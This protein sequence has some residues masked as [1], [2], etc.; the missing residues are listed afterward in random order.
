M[1]ELTNIRVFNFEGAIRGM[2]QPFKNTQKS[3][4][5]FG[6][7]SDEY[8][9]DIVSDWITDTFFIDSSDEFECV[10]SYYDQGILNLNNDED[11]IQYALLGP[12]DLD[13]AQRLVKAGS[14]HNKFLRQILVSFDIN[15]P[16]Y[17]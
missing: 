15:A 11:A 10:W 17:W 3:D 13:L 2:R 16:L 4:S 5:I 14:P 9:D 1:V 7:A 12:A 6:I 8:Y